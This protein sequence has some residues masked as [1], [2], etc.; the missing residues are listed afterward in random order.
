MRGRGHTIL[1]QNSAALL[2]QMLRMLKERGETETFL[3]VRR[4]LLHR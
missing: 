4:E 1:H 2:E 3:W